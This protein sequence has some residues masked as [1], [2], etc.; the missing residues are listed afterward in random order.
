MLVRR[1]GKRTN[2]EKLNLDLKLPYIG[3]S[4]ISNN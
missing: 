4:I 2:Q 3:K 1:Y